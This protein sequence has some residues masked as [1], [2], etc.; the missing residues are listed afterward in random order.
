MRQLLF[1]FLLFPAVFS[2]AQE[3]SGKVTDESGNPLE[4]VTVQVKGASTGTATTSSGNFR[5]RLNKLPVTLVFSAVNFKNYETKVTAKTSLSF[6]VILLRSTGTL[7]EVVVVG[8]VTS[9][10]SDYVAASS[11]VKGVEVATG[12]RT[13]YADGYSDYHS[14]PAGDHTSVKPKVSAESTR[15]RGL[16]STAPTVYNG[17]KLSYWADS[18]KEKAETITRAG[19]LTAGEVND[20]KKWKMWEDFNETEFKRYSEQWKITPTNRFSVQVQNRS[21]K[22]L[23]GVKVSLVDQKTNETIWT[24]ISDNTGKAELWAGMNG[25]E[26]SS[27]VVAIEGQKKV[28]PAAE[29]ANGLNLVEVDKDCGAS[30]KVQLSFVVDATG[31]M[32]DEIGYMKEELEDIITKTFEKNESLDLEMSSVFY[33]DKGDEYVTR[34]VDFEGDILKVVNF[35]KMQQA[36]GGGD[37]PEA[38]NDALRAAIDDLKWD[39]NARA[40]ILFIVLDAPP[41]D[42]AKAE[43]LG[44]MQRAAAK[45]IRVVPIACS[46][47]D[48]S[49]EFLMRSMALATNGTYLFLTDHSGVGGSH[50]APTT[51]SYS[52]ELLNALLQRTI[53]QMVF[54]ADCGKT[55]KNAEPVDP[56]YI[57]VQKIKI[58]PNP[59]SGKVIIEAAKEIKDVYVADF[60]GKLLKKIE[61]G[62]QKRFEIDLT[63]YPSAT[64]FI[65]YVSGDGKQGAEKIILVH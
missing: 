36:G 37:Y 53:E 16:A 5:I 14:F 31:S 40:R 26:M 19:L 39:D 49:T 33:R 12:G 27:Y 38:V 61:P 52:V 62:N 59:T 17:K 34:K 6:Q 54:V 8:Y 2:H 63:P 22:A 58:Y 45:G 56:K 7:E 57:S 55:E 25:K 10:R 3:F 13:G 9:K 32:G 35:I 42:E 15:I 65:R 4:G 48:K 43:M 11:T 28:F 30:N 29:F 20:F 50:I 21:H 46:G 23:V 51:D 24:A 44:L 1:L 60:S 41:H 64:Y 18:T 47:T